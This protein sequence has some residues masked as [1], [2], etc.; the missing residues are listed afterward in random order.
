MR[1]TGNDMYMHG[2]YGNQTRDQ[3]AVII[4]NI[5]TSQCNSRQTKD[6]ILQHILSTSESYHEQEYLEWT[7]TTTRHI[8][9]Q[10]S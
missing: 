9:A 1:T 5:F 6:G 8:T 2:I 3:A 10:H 7:H 4:D